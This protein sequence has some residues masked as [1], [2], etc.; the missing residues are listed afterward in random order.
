ML[1][2]TRV[3]MNSG[4]FVEIHLAF[5]AAQLDRGIAKRRRLFEDALPGPFRAAERR[6]ADR[7]TAAGAVGRG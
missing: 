5:D 3:P 4:R 2:S 1:W 7:E 6:E